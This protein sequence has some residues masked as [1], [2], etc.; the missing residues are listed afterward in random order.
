MGTIWPKQER[1]GDDGCTRSLFGDIPFFRPYICLFQ[2]GLLA[3]HIHVEVLT[4]RA[5]L[6]EKLEL[7][8]SDQEYPS[9][10]QSFTPVGMALGV[11]E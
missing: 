8:P 4:T 2:P 6:I 7:G 10:D 11:G 3:K 1:E 5:V 9:Q